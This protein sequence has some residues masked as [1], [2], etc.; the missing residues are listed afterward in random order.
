MLA[1]G[2]LGSIAFL[3]CGLGH[4]RADFAVVD[5]HRAG[6]LIRRAWPSSQVK[7]SM[8]SRISSARQMPR[9]RVRPRY[10]PG[11][12]ITL[13]G[14]GH[15][16]RRAG[17][18]LRGLAATSA[19]HAAAAHR[20]VEGTM[21]QQSVSQATAARCHAVDI[22]GVESTS[23]VRNGQAARERRR[24]VGESARGRRMSTALPIRAPLGGGP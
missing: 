11:V 14:N 20:C 17:K 8:G 19:Q 10:A 4:P 1:R 18:K 12:E 15:G 23:E 5:G 21:P 6:C 13:D 3:L 9:P 24:D 16:A 7:S 22:L 2:G